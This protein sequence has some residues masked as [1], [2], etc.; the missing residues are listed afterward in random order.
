MKSNITISLDDDLVQE[1]RAKN[2]N[3]SG[4]INSYFRDFLKPKKADYKK[5]DLTL[6]I[7]KFGEELA[8]TKEQAVFTHE[9]L[10][11]DAGSIWKNFKEN[12]D[13]G[14]SLFDYMDIRKKFREKFLGEVTEKNLEEQKT[15]KAIMDRD[16]A[17]QEQG[18]TD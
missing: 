15:T 6:N 3:I 13:P 10:N 4:T 16:A 17:L 9:N 1:L 12:Y 8:L 14:F 11:I 2:I 5:E 7:I 18:A